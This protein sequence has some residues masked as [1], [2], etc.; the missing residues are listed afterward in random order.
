MKPISWLAF[1]SVLAA[2]G[3]ASGG[4]HVSST[5]AVPTQTESTGARMIPYAL[6]MRTDA[7]VEAA[8][9]AGRTTQNSIGNVP[10]ILSVPIT[11]GLVDAPLYNL[12]QV[13][14]GIERINAIA[15]SGSNETEVPLSIFPGDAVVNVL[16]YQTFSA[17]VATA[18]IPAGSYDALEIVCDPATG[19]VVTTSGQTLPL[20]YGNFANGRFS[21]STTGHYSMVIP[22]NFNATIGINNELIDFNVENSINVQSNAAYVSASMFAT[23]AASAGAV[24]GTLITPSGAPV[25]NATAVVT[26]ESGNVV[27]LAPTDENGNFIVHAISAG[28]YTLTI[29]EKY[30]TNAGVTLTAS[31]GKTGTLAPQSVTIQAG[32][33]TFVGTLKD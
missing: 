6:P 32:F 18:M 4:S 28:R 23:S 10:T 3:C 14:I 24:G 16:D 29:D 11:I 2:S 25:Q 31:D 7:A 9:A 22:F 15:N 1:A 13:N 12:S 30:V 8:L 20:V 21:P 26:D 19:N 5:P 27:G 17:I 33:E